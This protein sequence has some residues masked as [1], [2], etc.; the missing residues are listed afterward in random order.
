MG[1][2]YQ[3]TDSILGRQVAIKLLHE[4]FLQDAERLVRFEREARVLASLNHP[5]IAAIHGLE[6]DKGIRF[7]VLEF[8]PGDTLAQRIAKGPLPIPEALEICRHVAE[9]LE[10]AHEKGIINRDLKP[11]NIKITPDQKAKVLDFGLAKALELPQ[12]AASDG[13]T[14]TIT[15]DSTRA[16]T[17]LATAAYMSP[18]QACGR[19]VDRKADLWSFGCI[20]Y[21]ALTRK[22]AF[23][24]A[25]STETL[26]AI[27][28]RDPD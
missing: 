2:V 24:G 4:P 25:T 6:Q 1:V 22:R 19:P 27:L 15:A 5:N 14:A 26:A 11:S 21:E 9:A 7:L 28:E 3:A 10:A 13:E 16:G 17:V 23:P 12:S 18:E 20:L 8:V